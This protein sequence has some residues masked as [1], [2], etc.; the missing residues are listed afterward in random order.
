MSQISFSFLISP[1]LVIL[2]ILS[3]YCIF[4]FIFKQ[5]LINL[6]IHKFLHELFEMLMKIGAK[7]YNKFC[8]VL[9]NSQNEETLQNVYTVNVFHTKL[10]PKF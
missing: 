1:N 7:W 9:I 8:L 4:F 6:D 10:Y 5:N 2:I 3:F